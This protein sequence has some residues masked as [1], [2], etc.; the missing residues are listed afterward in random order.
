MECYN[1]R[2]KWK[3]LESRHSFIYGDKE[4]RSSYLQSLA[5]CSYLEDEK[6]TIPIYTDFQGFQDTENKDCEKFRL[7][8]IQSS[9]FELYMASL[10][11]EKLKIELSSDELQKLEENISFLFL[12]ESIKK[13]DDLKKELQISMNA[14]KDFYEYY[15][16]TGELKPKLLEDIKLSFVTFDM[17]LPNLKRVVPSFAEFIF[18]IDKVKDFGSIYTKIINT[19]VASRSNAYLNIKI[20]CE[21]SSDWKN[22]YT[23]NGQFIE[24]VH[25]YEIVSMD[26]YQLT[27]TKKEQ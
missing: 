10:M 15:I 25:D 2:L 6:K 17:L 24:Y 11:F 5:K 3:I 20:G 22:Y 27:R 9:Y 1:E 8:S 16:T 4:K 13:F 12:E 18:I 7:N 21:N 14:F 19:Y 23:I 26:D